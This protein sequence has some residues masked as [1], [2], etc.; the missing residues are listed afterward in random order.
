MAEPT[1]DP[2][3]NVQAQSVTLASAHLE[4]QIVLDGQREFRLPFITEELIFARDAAAAFPDGSPWSAKLKGEAVI[5]SNSSNGQS[6]PLHVGESASID[7]ASVWLL[8]V[9]QP[10][11]G[12]LEGIDTPFTGRVWHLKGQ[13]TLL[14]RRGKRLN[15]IELEH[16]TISR[17]HATFLPDRHGQ[18]TLMS[19]SAGSAT[20]VNGEALDPGAAKRLRHGDLVGLGQLFFRFSVPAEASST[21]SLISVNTLGT[22]LV[23]IGGDANR[24]QE[25]RNEKSRWLLARLALQ[26]GEPLSV[27]SMLE[28]F[29]PG[30]STTRGRKN[31]SYTLLQLKESLALED[32]A[33]ESLIFRTPSTLQLNPERLGRHDYVEVMKMTEP[34][35]ALTSVVALQRLLNLYR[36]GFLKTCYEDWADVARSKLD[37]CFT[38][39]VLATGQALMEQGEFEA[40]ENAGRKLLEVDPLNEDATRMLMETYLQAAKP[41]KA[42]EAYEATVK[43]LKAEDLDPDPELMKLYYR[44]SMGL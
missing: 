38:E 1:S 2:T 12:T 3:Q 16:P 10:A 20:T 4:L 8:D 28:E 14:G 5:L 44:A 11:V 9:R 26:W 17:A 24:G 15:H 13:Q 42:V 40:V 35:K 31:L 33:F 32:V 25:V 30:V 37:I 27:E 19:E 43:A 34:R 6:Q 36:G 21:D 29:W 23:S 7:E 41:D 22:F 18:V 39:T